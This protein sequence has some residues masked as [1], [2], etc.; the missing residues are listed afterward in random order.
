MKWLDRFRAWQA[1]MAEK[2]RQANLVHC[3]V[4]NTTKL[5]E[6]GGLGSWQTSYECENG[7]RFSV[8][9]EGP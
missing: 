3:P 7:H 8:P 6:F 4:C 1:E 9:I 2:S 5:A